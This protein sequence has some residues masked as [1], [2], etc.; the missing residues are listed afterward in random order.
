MSVKKKNPQSKRNSILKNNYGSAVKDSY[1]VD[2]YKKYEKEIKINPRKKIS[3]FD[4]NIEN[5]DKGQF[6]EN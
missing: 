5:L 2:I 6:I 1:I 4:K 3:I